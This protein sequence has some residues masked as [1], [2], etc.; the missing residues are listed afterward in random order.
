M[1]R[2]YLVRVR[3]EGFRGINN[4]SDP[5]DL[6]FKSDAVNSIFGP[7]GLGKSSIYDA[8]SYAIRG[9]ISKLDDLPHAED[10]S[11]YYCNRFH[12]T[13]SSTIHLTFEPDDGGS[14]VEI[15]V[16]RSATGDRSVDS[17]TGYSAPEELLQTL[18]SDFVLLDQNAFLRFVE[19]SPLQRGRTFSGLLGLAKLSEYRQVLQ[20]LSHRRNLNTDFDISTLESQLASARRQRDVALAQARSHFKSLT[21]KELIVPLDPHVTLGEAEKS[22]AN[23]ELL[24]S[25]LATKRLPDVD[26]KEVH[27]CMRAAEKSDLRD[28]LVLLSQAYSTCVALKATS[29]EAVDQEALRNLLIKKNTLLEHTH[30]S[31]LPPVYQSTLRVLES[32]D[33]DE[34]LCPACETLREVPLSPEIKARQSAYQLVSECQQEIGLKWKSSVWVTRLK[35][36]EASAELTIANDDQCFHRLDT[37]FCSGTANV[38][39]LD[40][41]IARLKA[42][43]VLLKARIQQITKRKEEIEKLLPPSLVTLSQQIHHAEQLV[44]QIQQ[45]VAQDVNEST[46]SAQLAKRKKWIEFV[47][48]A[49]SVFSEAEVA[50][51]TNKAL[52]IESE[53][54]QMYAEITTNPAVVP[55]LQRASGTEDLHLRL[56]QF[57]GLTD[58]SA[59]TL[60]QESYRNALALAIFLSTALRSTQ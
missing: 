43:D 16:M 39:D 58:V 34:R 7:N 17:P 6:R 56:E 12:A 30:G 37:V 51:S 54:Q 42:V 49:F 21:G 57:Y 53:Y 13:G 36:V 26:F 1:I 28:E 33:W 41:A 2:Y 9:C 40:D 46:I 22:L 35:S 14:N 44:E 11:S 47:E 50:L 3:I 18:N 24:K 38:A 4:S 45:Y 48:K 27:E 60:L 59:T 55:K 32:A 8:L 29:E 10:A 19:E 20:T 23:I 25:H 31:L 52:A 5:L 15:R